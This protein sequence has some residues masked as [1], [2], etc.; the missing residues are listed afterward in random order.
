MTSYLSDSAFADRTVVVIGGGTGIGLAVA[1]HV[2]GAGGSVVLGGRTHQTLRD[3]A[4]GLGARARWA[5][6]D[7]TDD[8]SVAAF[9]ADVDVVHGLFTTA[10]SYVTGPIA[11]LSIADAATAFDTKFWGQYRVVKTALSSLAD[12]ASVVL[13]SGAAGA[14]PAGPAP[15]Y[16]AANSAVE[17][18]ARGLAVELAPIRVNAVAP[19]TV[20]GNL[21]QQRDP[22]V[23]RQAFDSYSAATLL[24]RVST[25]D[26]IATA[27]LH[28]F[29]NTTTTGTTVFPDGGYTLR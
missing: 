18:L 3:A 16:S 27:V 21:W 15:A 12:D 26:E 20:D 13:M 1:R 2:V 4:D 25:E 23:R 10:A 14:R 5:T 6:V 28:L 22:A 29:L 7:T 19:G 11:D 8:A 9:F 17:G 24:G